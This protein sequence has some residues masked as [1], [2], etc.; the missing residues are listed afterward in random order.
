MAR[1]V[2]TASRTYYVRSDALYSDA[3]GR[4]DSAA[5][6]CQTW[7][8]AVN[9]AAALDFG[10]KVV[11]IQHGSEGS[12]S[13]AAGVTIPTLTGG[14]TLLIKGSS[15]PGNTT[16]DTTGLG[17]S[18][19]ALRN[20]GTTPVDF[21][22]ITVV[23]GG[24]VGLGLIMPYDDSTAIIGNGV[25]FGAAT[26]AHVWVHDNKATAYALAASYSIIGGAQYH[27]RVN[28]GGAFLEGCTV[29]LTGTPAFSVAF[30]AVSNAGAL[31][32]PLSS[33]NTFTG[34]ATGSRYLADKNGVVD[35]QGGGATY[36]PG[37]A[38]GT[39]ATGGQYA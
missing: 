24:G 18:C 28:M 21:R 13:F 8:Q 22:D 35:T 20:T 34:A 15:T 31:Q 39:T 2:L 3:P 9:L 32:A 23:G 6:A 37:N 38:V 33:S 7:Q 26:Y 4:L 27:F 36:F 5:G 11:T 25:R 29:T 14:G 30:V 12:A 1:E 16:V 10:G 17:L 19:F